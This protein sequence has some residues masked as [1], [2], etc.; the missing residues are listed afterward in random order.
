MLEGTLTRTE[1]ILS[2]LKTKFGEKSNFLYIFQG[3]SSEDL[4]EERKIERFKK[5]TTI[6]SASKFQAIGFEPQICICENCQKHSGSCKM[7]KEHDVNFQHL[8]TT[9]LQSGLF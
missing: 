9:C 1:E 5:Y 4:D 3:I 8:K 2:L 7:F 6:K